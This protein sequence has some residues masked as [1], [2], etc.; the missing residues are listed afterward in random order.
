MSVTGR[1]T[2]PAE[3]ARERD[4]VERI[5]RTLARSVVWFVVFFALWTTC[6]GLMLTMDWIATGCP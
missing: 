3:E 2:T 6:V 1:W 4:S 5:T